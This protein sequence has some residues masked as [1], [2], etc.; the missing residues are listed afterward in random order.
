MQF[1]IKIIF[2]SLLLGSTLF[3]K[4][5][6]VVTALNGEASVKRDGVTLP[7]SLGMKLQ[8]RDSVV[9]N[10]DAKVQIIFNDETIITV[11]KSSEFSINEYLFDEEKEEN[12]LQFGLLRGAMRT[13][14]GKIGKIAP[15]KFAVKTKTATIGIRGTNFTIVEREDAEIVYCTYGAIS[16]SIN[17]SVNIVKQ[18]FYARVLDGRALIQAFTPQELHSIQKANFLA[19]TSKKKVN[20]S[21]NSEQAIAKAVSA[22]QIDTTR[23][24]LPVGAI[25]AKRVSADVRDSKQISEEEEHYHYDNSNDN[26]QDQ[27]PDVPT[28]KPENNFKD[29]YGYSVVLDDNP[30][31]DVLASSINL[32]STTSGAVSFMAMNIST[33]EGYNW[34]KFDLKEPLSGSTK[35]NFTTEFTSAEVSSPTDNITNIR[36]DSSN[37]EATSDDLQSGDVMTW[38]IWDV[39]LLY[40]TDTLKNQHSNFNGLWVAGERTSAEIISSF[41]SQKVSYKGIYK[42]KEYATGSLIHNTASM[43]VDFGADTAVLNILYGTGR[44]FNVS[45]AVSGEIYGYQEPI[46][47]NSSEYGY[48]YGAF[49]GTKGELVG[50]SFSTTS[51]GYDSLELRGV[52]ELSSDALTDA[53]LNANTRSGWVVDYS[54]SNYANHLSYEITSDNSFNVQDSYLVLNSL[55]SSTG[56]SDYWELRVAAQPVSYTSSEKFEGKF[57]SVYMIPQDGGSSKNAEILSSKFVATGD[58]LAENDYMSW[59]YWDATLSY[60]N[61]DGVQKHTLSGFWQSGE[62]TPS[63]VVDA[64]TAQDV[65]YAGIYRAVDFTQQNS[66]INGKASLNVDFGADTAVLSID[67]AKGRVYDMTLEG[68]TLSGSL[69]DTAGEAYGTFY[70]SD[71]SSVGG[72]FLTETQQN[73]KELRGVYEVTKVS[74]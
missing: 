63:S 67:Y 37:F 12:S 51:G 2:L 65:A 49:Y 30:S 26:P 54:S 18:G 42:A 32:A 57:N 59:G 69:R 31:A 28:T 71:A 70:G 23:E 46:S 50:G 38:G 22:P 5:V 20:R 41:G 4:D 24:I 48:V 21:S 15:Q 39:N 43:D 9:T 6:A 16:V 47:Q 73:T 34:W 68:N 3:S 33:A 11:G 13:I 74:N 27:K 72:N 66:L 64:I 60:E 14:T 1:F 36:I 44:T 7:L 10:A 45:T 8:E 19:K 29:L 25:A 35:D 52:F 56:E 58:D 61:E 17:N 40:D 55:Q 53:V 62:P